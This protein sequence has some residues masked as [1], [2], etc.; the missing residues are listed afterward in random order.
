MEKSHREFMLEAS[1]RF[2]TMNFDQLR[3]VSTEVREAWHD[4]QRTVAQ[5]KMEQFAEGEM[6]QVNGREGNVYRGRI[7]YF[8]EKSVTLKEEKTGMKILAPLTCIE[9]LPLPKVA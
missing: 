4:L 7:Q 6:V 5:R 8:N 1:R 9:K 3:D 2:K